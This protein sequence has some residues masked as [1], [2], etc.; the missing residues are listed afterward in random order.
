[1]TG[2]FD[3]QVKIWA[4]D[5]KKP[6]AVIDEIVSGCPGEMDGLR[7]GDRVC[8]ANGALLDGVL[9]TSVLQGKESV[10]LMICLGS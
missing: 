4:G 10:E 6:V 7:V 3:R 5:A 2:G 9:L 8:A 1:M